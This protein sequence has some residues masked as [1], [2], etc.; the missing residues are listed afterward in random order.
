MLEPMLCEASGVGLA[1][2]GWLYDLKLDG[3]RILCDK[4]GAEVDLWYRT[5]RSATSS[6]PEIARAVADLPFDDAVLDGEI[7]AFDTAGKPSFQR[8]E[9][10]IGLGRTR[11]IAA[12][13]HQVPVA[14]IAFDLLALEERDLRELPLLERRRVLAG[15]LP[16]Q[17][18]VRSLDWMEDDGTT[19]FDMCVRERMEGVIAKRAASRYASGRRTSD[20]VKI[21]CQSDEDFVVVGFTRG[22]GARGDLGALDLATYDGDALVIRG[23]VGSGL[24][25]KTM[26]ALVA[27]LGALAVDSPQAVGEY[28]SAP[29]GR[30]HVRPEVVVSV[31][32]ASWTDEG[33]LRFPVFRGVREDVLPKD[34]RGAPPSA[35]VHEDLADYWAAVSGAMLPYVVGRSRIADA[36]ALAQVS[37]PLRIRTDGWMALD[38]DVA[39]ARGAAA[40]LADLGLPVFAKTGDTTDYQLLAAVGD[41][42]AVA[43]QSLAELVVRLAGAGVVKVA[44]SPIL[45]PY[46]PVAGAGSRVST[47]VALTELVPALDP[48]RFTTR[49]VPARLAA[50]PDPMAPLLSA[51]VDFPAA[52]A[53]L[54]ARLSRV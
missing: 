33:V 35:A 19:L 12:A 42:P 28:G 14:Y 7:V 18:L 37:P 48:R 49:T 16:E 45:A 30:T 46:S 1:A 24:D 3:V 25:D 4:R 54:E 21:K 34:C 52:V 32:Y 26:R 40:L 10:R 43:V 9:Q 15:I 47:P 41:A 8:L 17:G 36:A 50:A 5:G 51:R 39:G 53:R 27:R 13:E 29:R 31:R 23:K 2:K 6:Y 20:W 22:T 44:K 38:C 11:D